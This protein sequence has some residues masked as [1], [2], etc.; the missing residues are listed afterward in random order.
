MDQDTVRAKTDWEWWG[1]LWDNGAS[2]DE[3]WELAHETN[4]TM[5]RGQ[6]D[7]AWQWC[8]LNHERREVAMQ[9]WVMALAWTF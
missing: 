8:Q 5:T 3:Y 7:K 6:F 4:T 2:E 9:E 1:N